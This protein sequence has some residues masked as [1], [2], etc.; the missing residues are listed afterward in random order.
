VHAYQCNNHTKLSQMI[1]RKH[2]QLQ[3]NTVQMQTY[4]FLSNTSCFNAYYVFNYVIT[5][6]TV[7][8]ITT[9]SRNGTL[10]RYLLRNT[11]LLS[12]QLSQLK[13][14]VFWQWH[15]DLVLSNLLSVDATQG[16]L[17][18]GPE[19]PIKNGPTIGYEN[20]LMVVLLWKPVS[21]LLESW[22]QWRPRRLTAKAHYSLPTN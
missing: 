21:T 11:T 18:S 7:N 3:Q 4:R 15:T 2:N 5:K 12:S 8:N 1:E 6:T 22:L 10:C 14:R 17:G 16:T 13:F 19:L 20:T 9:L